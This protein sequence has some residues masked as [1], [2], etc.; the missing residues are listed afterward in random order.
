MFSRAMR[1]ERVADMFFFRIGKH[2]KMVTHIIYKGWML[3]KRGG[4]MTKD[5]RRKC[6]EGHKWKAGS[7]HFQSC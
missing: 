1:P 2:R 4:E 6:V 7:T 5:R 3:I